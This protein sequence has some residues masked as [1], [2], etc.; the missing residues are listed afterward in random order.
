MK[1]DVGVSGAVIVSAHNGYKP[2]IGS[3]L[4]KGEHIA[5]ILAGRIEKDFCA[6]WIN[7]EGKILMPGLVNG[8]CHG[9][10]TLARGLGDDMTL[11]EQNK[12]FSDTNWFYT[13]IQDEDRYYAR[14][15]T[16]C[17]ALLSGTTFIMENMYWGL[18]RKSVDAMDETGIRGAL[19]EDVRVDFSNPDEFLSDDFLSE[20]VKQCRKEQKIPVLGSVSEED[21][22]TKRL[23]RIKKIAE[24]KDVYIT[25]HLAENTWRQD[26]VKQ[27]YQTTAV[28]YLYQNNLLGKNLIG[29]HV[30]YVSETE[31]KQLAKTDTKVVNTP[32][33]EMKIQDGVAPIPQ[34]IHAG[35]T[36]CLGTDGAMWN[37]SNDIFR[38]MKGMYLLHSLTSGTRSLKKTDILD[39]ATINGA[40]CFGLEKEYG[41]IEVGKKA[42]FILIETRTPHMQP[43]IIGEQETVT[44]AIVFNAT[45][46]DVTD[47]FV[48]GTQVVKNRCLLTMD[49]TNVMNRV[50]MAA[51]KIARALSS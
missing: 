48:D 47:V 10:M 15:L 13:L 41:T 26:L 38:E 20:Y 40:K 43:L 2:F 3:V 49:V 34:M 45:G 7:G 28:D 1:Y 8:H 24:E 4:V 32:L 51:E 31:I 23:K 44:S 22:D 6:E 21:Y 36:V 19:A 11:F 30:V 9:D 27:K 5:E 46:S 39:M 14:Q 18:G 12:K 37:N 50:Q 16:Y 33:C 17:E 42:D 35:V 29:S 25:C